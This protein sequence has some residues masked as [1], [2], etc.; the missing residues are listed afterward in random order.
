M[1]RRLEVKRQLFHFILGAWIAFWVWFLEPYYGKLVVL[2]LLFTVIFML[3]IPRL[4]PTLH[5]PN[6][7]LHHFE[8]ECDKE[9]FPFKGAIYYGIG[10]TPAILLLPIE[11]ATI[12][13]I[14]L[15]VGDSLATLV[16]KFHGRRRVGLKSVEG[17]LAF[18]ISSF[19]FCLVFMKLA[20]RMDLLV[21]SAELCILGALIEFQNK[22]D[23]NLAVPIGLTILIK[24]FSV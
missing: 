20:G 9:V 2:P 24:V 19:V 7:L 11:L 23:D 5:I 1:E 10:I 21:K 6:K 4:L 17:S 15:S 12:V 16:G 14:I 13:I 18:I 3:L 8:R 22:I